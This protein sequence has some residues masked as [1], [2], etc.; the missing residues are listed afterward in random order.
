MWADS[1]LIKAL[2]L[3]SLSYMFTGVGKV[4][5]VKKGQ[6]GFRSTI[7]S[8]KAIRDMSSAPKWSRIPVLTQDIAA[9]L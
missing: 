1:T 8:R 6:K 3:I 7:M 5:S 4:S 2:H 9:Q